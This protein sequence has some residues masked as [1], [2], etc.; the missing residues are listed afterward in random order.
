MWAFFDD[1][2]KPQCKNNREAS[3]IHTKTGNLLL[4]KRR[5]GPEFMNIEVM[6]LRLT[7]AWW[8][9]EDRRTIEVSPDTLKVSHL[10]FEIVYQALYSA[11]PTP[12]EIRREY[13]LL[14]C[15]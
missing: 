10:P 15:D 5:G 3:N 8:P 12:E 9:S 4:T 13:F 6:N 7:D 14:E 11:S 1:L 2:A